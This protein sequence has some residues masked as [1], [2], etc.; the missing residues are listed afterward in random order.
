LGQVVSQSEVVLRRGEWK[1][2]GEGVVCSYGA[3]DLLHPGHLRLLEQARDF[4][5]VLIVAVLSDASVLAAQVR[6]GGAGEAA[7]R[8]WPPRPVAPSAERAEILAALAAVD[9][10]VELDGPPG[11]FL[12][13]LQPDVVVVGTSS[14]R[15]SSASP[16][17]ADE[18]LAAFHG[19]IVRLPLEPG[20]STTHLIERIARSRP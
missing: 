20:Y 19:N 1:R 5:S 7:D 2:T 9:F 11:Q 12:E 3:F 6:P 18:V 16:D 17:P 13:R 15:E 4:G 14:G 8:D 10:V